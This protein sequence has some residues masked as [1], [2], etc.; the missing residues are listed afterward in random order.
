MNIGGRSAMNQNDPEMYVGPRD[1]PQLASQKDDYEA[2]K[3]QEQLFITGK[4]NDPDDERN[5]RSGI[6]SS[7]DKQSLG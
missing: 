6:K 3:K 5:D 4:F 7:R 1:L 2:Q